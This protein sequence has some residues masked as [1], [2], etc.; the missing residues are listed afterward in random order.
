MSSECFIDIN[1]QKTLRTFDDSPKDT[2]DIKN[3]RMEALKLATDIAFKI[4]HFKHR[5]E[6]GLEELIKD[7]NLVYEIADS[8]LQ[9]IMGEK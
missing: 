4:D 6:G 1:G 2:K 8:N 7:L 3:Y 5:Y 9:Y